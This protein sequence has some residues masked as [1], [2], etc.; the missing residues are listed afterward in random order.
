MAVTGHRYDM[1]P[2]V[3]PVGHLYP[4]QQDKS[5]CGYRCGWVSG[6]LRVHLCPAL[7]IEQLH[8]YCWSL[9]VSCLSRDW[10]MV[11]PSLELTTVFADFL[12]KEEMNQPQM[13]TVERIKTM[14]IFQDKK[15][16]L[17]CTSK[18]SANLYPGTL[19][20]GIMC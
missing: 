4:Q 6:P 8:A 13:M 18:F 3:R 2:P 20:S 5:D 15:E 17:P 9:I 14:E 12:K 16:N 10:M 19:N 1:G 7:S 11:P